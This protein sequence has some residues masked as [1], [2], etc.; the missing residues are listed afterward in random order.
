MRCQRYRETVVAHARSA[1]GPG[2]LEEAL[3]H[4][5]TCASCRQALAVQ[6]ELTAELRELA[7][8]SRSELPSD[9]LETRLL[10]AFE[11]HRAAMT[12]PARGGAGTLGFAR[13]RWVMWPAA[14]GL[15]VAAGAVG[16]LIV[17][18]PPH[19]AAAPAPAPPAGVVELVGFQ[20]LP[21]AVTLPDFDS[22]EIVRTEIAV[23]ALPVYGVGI[24]PG[25]AGGAVKVDLLVGQDGYPRAIRLVTEELQGTRSTR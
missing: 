11:Q 3:A 13:R 16:W 17:A 23:T 25:A 5:Q 24:P 15:A 6:Q 8:L 20:P 9:A 1:A 10:A 7:A 18:R 4:L 2:E 22:G 21:Q 14:A 12:K 19:R